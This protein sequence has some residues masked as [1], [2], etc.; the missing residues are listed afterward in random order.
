MISLRLL[1]SAAT[2][3]RSVGSRQ[4]FGDQ[5]SLNRLVH[6]FATGADD[7]DPIIA[8]QLH[9]G[10]TRTAFDRLRHKSDGI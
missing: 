4:L 8:R 5:R 3:G 1:D 9:G 6:R 2:H 10:G 7:L